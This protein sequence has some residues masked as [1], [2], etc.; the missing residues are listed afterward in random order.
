M[1]M[2]RQVQVSKAAGLLARQRWQLEDKV[3]VMIECAGCGRVVERRV[4]RSRVK[5]V[6][7]CSAKCRLR[8]FR[9]RKQSS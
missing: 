2:K 6:K 7:Y 1:T 5:L 8:A 4:A 9:R 3:K